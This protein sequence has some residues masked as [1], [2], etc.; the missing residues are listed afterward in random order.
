[1]EIKTQKVSFSYDRHDKVA[2][3]EVSL[4]VL[5]NQVTGIIGNNGS[6]KSTLLY[7]LSGNC[8]PK[9]GKVFIGDIILSKK[10]YFEVVGLIKEKVGYLPQVLSDCLSNKILRDEIVDNL[11]ELDID[12]TNIDDKIKEFFALL[13]LDVSLL[14]QYSYLLSNGERRKIAIVQILIHNPDIIIL[15]EPTASLDSNSIKRLINYLTKLKKLQNKTIIV[16]SND[17]DFI[18]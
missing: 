3:D 1:M 13:E 5:S 15:D 11:E 7:L 18:I 17:V 2:I 4:K 9:K 10:N 14:S 6:G 12:L 16:A 8:I